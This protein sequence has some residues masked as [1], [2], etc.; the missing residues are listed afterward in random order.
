MKHTYTPPATEATIT[1]SQIYFVPGA[2]IIIAATLEHSNTEII[3]FRPPIDKDLYM[4]A[5]G[6][7]TILS[8]D[9]NHS[10]FSPNEPRFIVRK[11]PSKPTP[12]IPLDEAWE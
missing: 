12:A 5:T 9:A 3:A 1:P 11:L 4:S 7:R 8:Q 10:S 2:K 6:S